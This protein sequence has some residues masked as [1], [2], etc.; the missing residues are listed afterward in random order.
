MTAIR[1]SV[2][3]NIARKA[4]VGFLT[5]AAMVFCPGSAP[6][7]RSSSRH[8]ATDAINQVFGTP[9]AAPRLARTKDGDVSPVGETQSNFARGNIFFTSATRCP[10]NAGAILEK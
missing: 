8:D 4:E 6:C 2:N 1:V 5:A 9:A 7:G 10:H 3:S